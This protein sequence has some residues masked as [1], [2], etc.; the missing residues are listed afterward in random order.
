MRCSWTTHRPG[1]AGTPWDAAHPIVLDTAASIELGYEPAGDY[2]ATFADEVDWLVSAARGG[3]GS[4]LLPARD[5]EYF[6]PLLDYEAEDRRLGL[7]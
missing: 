7:G 5:D 3:E 6:G 2:A 1:W 4:A